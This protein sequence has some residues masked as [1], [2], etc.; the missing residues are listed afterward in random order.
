L[1]TYD[2]YKSA[3]LGGNVALIDKETSSTEKNIISSIFACE[4]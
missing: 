1:N 2:F 4:F 3:L